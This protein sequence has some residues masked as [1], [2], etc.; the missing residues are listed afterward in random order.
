MA[1]TETSSR[2]RPN[3]CIIA[4]ALIHI[5]K[6]SAFWTYYRPYGSLVQPGRNVRIADNTYRTPIIAIV[7]AFV[8]CDTCE[9]VTLRTTGCLPPCLIEAM[10]LDD[11]VLDARGDSE[12]VAAG[13]D[14]V[15]SWLCFGRG[16]WR[17]DRHYPCRLAKADLY[18]ACFHLG[19]TL[20][21]H[22]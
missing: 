21:H 19:W 15:P 9:S 16:L 4:E 14:S 18:S 12:C 2:I 10:H 1:S 11:F 6:N 5:L 20:S 22:T 7:P 17:Y 3:Y 13:P 8:A